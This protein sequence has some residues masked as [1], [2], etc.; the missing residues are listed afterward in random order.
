MQKLTV[1]V[2]DDETG[3]CSG[4]ER[5]LRKFSVDYPFMD[6]VIGFDIHSVYTGEDAIE[7]IDQTQTDVVLLDNKL[8]GIQGNDVLE[9]INQK[10][11]DTYVIMI[12]SHASLEVAVKAT[13][14]GAYDFVPKPFTPQELKSAMENVTRHIF[15]KRMTTKLNKEG[16]QIRFQFLS[17]MSH[18]LKAPINAI[19]GYIKMMQRREFG[20]QLDDYE[21][22]LER[23]KKRTESMQNLIMDM[24]DL[25]QIESGKKSRELARVNLTEIAYSAIDMMKPYAIQKDVKVNIHGPE[26]LELQ[27]DADEMEIILNNLISN[28]IKYNKQGGTV[29]CNIR[30]SKGFA[31][32]TVSDTG[33]GMSKTEQARLF[34]EFVRIKNEKTKNISGSGLGLSIV[35]KL[36]DRYNGDINVC[37]KPEE[38]SSFTVTLPAYTHTGEEAANTMNNENI[39][40]NLDR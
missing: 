11:Y 9:Y 32:I 22:I 5:I 39:N 24:L 27:A 21:E 26:K 37:S 12:T 13:K 6:N 10:Q 28:A 40:Q 33:I 3:I 20:E 8:P 25:T 1:L 2:V 34:N 35:K 31:T 19:E 14:N 38:G 4:I 36:V 30:E 18:E 17:V 7:F 15:L 23:L 29:D 16:K